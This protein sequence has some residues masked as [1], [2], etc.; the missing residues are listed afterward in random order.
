MAAIKETIPN[1][2]TSRSVSLPERYRDL[3]P[4]G[5]GGMGEVRRVHDALV[6]RTVA[7]KVLHWDHI[8]SDTTRT[9][10]VREA[11]IMA[12]LQH[13]GVVPVHE[14]GELPD[15]RPWFVMQEVRG[16]CLDEILTR[17]H[18]DNPDTTYPRDQL[19]TLFLRVSETIA[20]AHSKGVVHRDIKPSNLM[21]GEFGEALVMDW[22]I[23]AHAGTASPAGEA[24]GDPRLTR[25]GDVVG[26]LAY[27]APEQFRDAPVDPRSDVYALGLVLY[28]ILTG[29]VAQQGS[30]I[31]LLSRLDRKQGLAL[32]YPDGVPSTLRSLVAKATHQSPES[33]HNSASEFAS[34]LRSWL[35]G[36]ERRTRARSLLQ[37]AI[38][39]RKTLEQLR[40]DIRTTQAKIAK[41]RGDLEHYDRAEKKH[42]LWR[43]E[44]HALLLRQRRGALTSE[45]AET[46]SRCLQYDPGMVE[47][48]AEMV[49]LSTEMFEL[50]E[51]AGDIPR[52]EHWL[53]VLRTH[54]PGFE[55][56]SSATLSLQSSPTETA[57]LVQPCRLHMRRWELVPDQAIE[58]QTPLESIELAPGRY[59]LRLTANGH[60]PISQHVLLRRREHLDL[61]PLTL[62]PKGSLGANDV[63]VPAGEFIAGGDELASEP[64]K[65]ERIHLRSFVIQR[66]PVTNAEYLEFLNDLASK[67]ELQE[68]HQLAPQRP[69]A[70]AKGHLPAFAF[71]NGV[72]SLPPGDEFHPAQELDWPV[73]QVDWHSANA[74]ADWFARKTGLPWR[75]PTELEW[76]KAARG[77]DGRH[78]PWGDQ[79]EPSWA[80]IM[81]SFE[82]APSQRPID[83]FP[84]DCSPF[85]VYGMAGN[86]RDW[87]ANVWTRQG[88]HRPEPTKSDAPPLYVIRGGGWTTD[89]GGAR[90][91]NRYAAL[92]TA[93]FQVVGFRLAHSI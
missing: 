57:V 1:A 51:D 46:L 14:R 3:G 28:E 61:E 70:I 22:G 73:S 44:D 92:S 18:G 86:V 74:Y 91:A 48:T 56:R 90:V 35:N 42:T 39:Q 7:L 2:S 16:E 9:R 62:P 21:V 83:D 63:F 37:A 80:A 87:C 59:L 84:T 36:S 53:Q 77:V 66:F 27:M 71:K 20:Y 54:A 40:T 52:S 89:I 50:Y 65:E 43:A 24:S 17:H 49:R 31:A 82:D 81:N 64:L 75:L 12:M 72:F 78:F 10:F 4:I 69:K 68:A 47:A 58:L 26:T 8:D 79:P 38:Q 19:L 32:Q 13:P 6:D 85:G 93:R 45:L 30:P 15:G 23:A 11:S 67:G 55:P 76:E 34:E 60:D 29:Q 41:E 88:P 5:S 33:R 25:T